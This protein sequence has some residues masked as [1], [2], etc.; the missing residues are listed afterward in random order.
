M[1]KRLNSCTLGRKLLWSDRMDASWKECG[2]AH[3]Y[4]FSPLY[5]VVLEYQL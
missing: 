5:V 4:T 1:G 2:L 3:T